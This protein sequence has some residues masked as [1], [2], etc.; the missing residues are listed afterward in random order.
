MIKKITKKQEKTIPFFIDKWLKMATRKINKKQCQKAVNDI[1]QEMRKD[2]PIIIYG[3]SP[4]QTVLLAS[5]F[6][7]LTN[8]ESSQL[9]S[10]LH[11]LLSLQLNPRLESQ[12][13]SQLHSQ[14]YSLLYSQLESRLNSLLY[15]QLESQLESQLHSQLHSRLKEVHSNSYIAIWWLIWCGWY[16]YGRYIGI[17]YDKNLYNK[18]ISFVKEVNYIIPYEKIC[19][20][21]EKPVKIQWKNKQLHNDTG[22][23]VE[24]A[25]GYGL[26]CLNGVNVGRKIVMTPAGELDPQLMLKEKNA[27]V[28]REIIRKIGIEKVID[29]LGAKVIEKRNG[30]ELLNFDIG[31][32][33][34]RPFLKM[35]NPSIGT[36][37]IEGVH[38]DCDTIDKALNSRNGF[39]LDTKFIKPEILT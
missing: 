39:K 21:S 38:P 3:Q 22:L 1:Y 30:Y 29:S 25:D 5:L 20:I 13:R 19:F 17:K 36:W 26:Y 9:H 15:S 14:L 27:E 24:Y 37:H 8:K 33:R 10:Q 31:N 7:C 28:R 35:R 32:G 2:K 11:L 23:A 4:M 16:D 6:L 18:F 34:M 12:L